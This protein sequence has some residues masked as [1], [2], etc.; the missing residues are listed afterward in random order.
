[1]TR[2]NEREAQDEANDSEMSALDR[3]RRQTNHS[4]SEV[5]FPAAQSTRAFGGADGGVGC[6]SGRVCDY[7]HLY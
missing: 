3:E 7:E 4:G 6:D 2:T 5:C 1:M